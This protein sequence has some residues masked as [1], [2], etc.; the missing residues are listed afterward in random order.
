MR[1]WALPDS[2]LAAAPE[3]PWGFPAELFRSRAELATPGDLTYTN[4]R[5]R[6]ALPQ[7]GTGLD[8][9]CGAGAASLPLQARCS[10]VIGVDESAEQLAE[11]RRQ[12]RPAGV[13]ARAIQ[14]A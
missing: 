9:G 8:V 10:L 6:G 14:G 7:G 12:A 1:E 3:S 5:A 11:F 13:A 2:I 4:R